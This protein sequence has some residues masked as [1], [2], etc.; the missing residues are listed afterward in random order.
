MKS[1]RAK[2]LSLGMAMLLLLAASG[3]TITTP[4]SVG[5]I[6]DVEIPAGIYLLAQY[7]AYNTASGDADLATGESARDVKAVL[8][9]EC[10]GTIGDEEV[11]TD[12]ADYIAQLTLRSLE[13]YAAVETMFDELGGVLD[14]AATSEAADTAAS[15]WESNGDL[16]AAN[17]IS[18][19]TIEQYLLNNQKAQACLELLYGENG[20]TPVTEAEY[21]DYLQNECLYIDE[22][23]LPLFDAN[24]YAFADE[25]QAAEIQALAEECAAT[26]NEWATAEQ[27]RSERQ[28]SM[29]E[30]ASE[31]IPRTGEILGATM[32]S[33]QALQYISSQLMTPDTLTSYGDSLTEAADAA[34]ENTWFTY[35]TGMSVAVMCSV[36]PLEAYSLQELIEGYDLLRTMKGTE[37][38]NQFY[39]EGAALAHNLD[40]SAMNT[41][42]PGNIK[43]EV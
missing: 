13:Y 23:Q 3:C 26:L 15:V 37:M 9:A 7:N 40:Q 42:K 4:S 30:A 41:Y 18:Q 31:Y 28:V 24:T 11:T 10:T 34:G 36:D 14:D 35:D 17:G 29:I 27:G 39:A 19:A 20:Q 6:G 8:R 2:F 43:T 38:D 21:T 5:S 16:Y 22:V 33:A 1:L 32:E 25:E 12:G